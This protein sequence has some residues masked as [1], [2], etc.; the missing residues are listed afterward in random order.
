M[1]IEKQ[2]TYSYSLG[3][4]LSLDTHID[5]DLAFFKM[6]PNHCLC[7]RNVNKHENR[8]IN[9]IFLLPRPRPFI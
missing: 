9:N 6:V 3:L 1:K 8:K 2:T 7:L 4:D 5:E